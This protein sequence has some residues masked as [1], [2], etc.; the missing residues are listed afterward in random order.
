MTH[1]ERNDAIKRLI[2]QRTKVTT[3]SRKVARETLINEGVY[4]K[5]GSIRVVYGGS[6]AK[7]KSK[8]A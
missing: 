6:G 5:K 2:K 3:V 4:T 7:K 8:V 1:A